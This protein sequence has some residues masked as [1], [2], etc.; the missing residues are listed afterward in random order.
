MKKFAVFAVIFALVFKTA[1]AVSFLDSRG[2]VEILMY[3]RICTDKTCRGDYCITPETFE[4]DLK[5]F[6]K[7]GFSSVFASEL[8][9]TDVKGRKIVVITFDDGYKSD[10][11]YAV[12]L[13]EKYG[14]CASFYIFGGA[15][16]TDGYLTKDDV[17]RLSE[18]K[19][20]EIG[21]HTYGLH[22]LL[23]STLNLMYADKNCEDKIIADF[24]KNGEFLESIIGK[25]VETASYPNGEFSK[26]VDKRLKEG[27]IKT[28]FSTKW[29]AFSGISKSYPAGRKNRS[30]KINIENLMK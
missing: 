21:N 5:Y 1:F 27:G 19:C 9:G 10:I 26:S 14:Y 11:E 4:N 8:G 25:K 28:T 18:K 13:L 24:N 17:K 16:G 20:A 3:H 6:K 23:P 22:S 7:K 12:P 29:Y 2:R 15:V 30:M